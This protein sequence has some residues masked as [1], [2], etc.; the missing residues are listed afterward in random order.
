[1]RIAIVDND[2]S[3]VELISQLLKLNFPSFTI[4]GYLSV[5]ELLEKDEDIDIL[6]LDIEMPEIN[7]LT[8][9]RTYRNY[10]NIVFISSHSECMVDAF[11][12]N[13]AGFIVKNDNMEKRLIEKIKYLEP[14]IKKH[15]A[16]V[17]RTVEGLSHLKDYEIMFFH[18]EE[19]CIFM[20]TLKNQVRLTSPSL[21]K[22]MNQLNECFFLINRNEIIN[23]QFITTFIRKS[24]E[25]KLT[26]DIKFKVSERKWK[27]LLET[28]NRVVN[29]G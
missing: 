11:D 9:A 29:V 28:Y 22:L 25:V 15:E 7:G 16:K 6:L 21:S 17:Y 18:S 3:C 5:N 4:H 10:A 12:V 24:Y 14:M 2:K 27:L 19:D 20:H 8:F 23:M 26:N 1:M 13:V